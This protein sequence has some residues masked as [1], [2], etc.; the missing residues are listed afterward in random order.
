[1]EPALRK[2]LIRLVVVVALL[3]MIPLV[4]MQFTEEVEWTAFD[5]IVAGIL[6][7]GTGLLYELV[8]RRGGST[9]Y[10]GGVGVACAAG[11]L[12][13]WVNLAVGLIGSEDNPANALYCAVIAVGLI[14]VSISS[15]KPRGMALAMFAT[16]A[17]QALVPV[18]AMLIWQPPFT[19]GLVQVLGANTLFVSL[20]VISASLF[21]HAATKEPQLEQR[22]A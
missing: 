3:L 1:M 14:G 13:I 5:F 7:F 12:L 16:A 18:I 17:V 11:L 20:W 22:T 4:A 10:R 21:R 2:K 9:A 15:L 19:L 8:A 6:L